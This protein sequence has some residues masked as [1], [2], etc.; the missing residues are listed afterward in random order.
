MS[1]GKVREFDEGLLERIRAVV[2]PGDQIPTLTS[3]RPNRIVSIGTEGIEVETLRTEDLG[4]G[5][6]LVPAWMI[7]IA[8][9][10]L[11]RHGQ[12]SQQHL[13]NELGV[14]R[15]AFVFAL[16]AQFRDV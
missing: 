5:A 3:K 12:L 16:F 7:S 10:H 6:Q 11:R 13:L 9:E 2:K 15:S 1:T 14:K 4:S 8:W